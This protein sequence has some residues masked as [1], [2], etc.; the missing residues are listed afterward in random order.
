[1]R[2][3]QPVEYLAG[4]VGPIASEGVV[5]AKA[6]IEVL[7]PLGPG[8]DGVTHGGEVVEVGGGG[9]EGGEGLV[10]EGVNRLEEFPVDVAVLSEVVALQHHSENVMEV[11]QQVVLRHRETPQQVR[12]RPLELCGQVLVCD[13]LAA[14]GA[15]KLTILRPLQHT[16]VQVVHERRVGDVGVHQSRH[17]LQGRLPSCSVVEWEVVLAG[18]VLEDVQGAPTNAL[19]RT[20]VDESYLE[21]AR[22]ES[23]DLHEVEGVDGLLVGQIRRQQIHDVGV[24]VLQIAKRPSDGDPQACA[25]LRPRRHRRQQLVAMRI[26]DSGEC[27]KEGC[28]PVVDEREALEHHPHLSQA[29]TAQVL[30]DN[31]AD[32][33]LYQRPDLCRHLHL[34]ETLQ[35]LLARLPVARRLAED[36]QDGKVLLQ[37]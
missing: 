8:D 12:E 17:D 29:Q 11:G 27:A 33:G 31:R 5:L 14:H 13:A 15:L 3:T 10:L 21:E 2:H 19:K 36:A 16:V 26:D 34:T 30:V 25:L 24:P 18:P 35:C 4:V 1:M 32:D 23:D 9:G 28:V 7:R 20:L 22:G 37:I 6:L